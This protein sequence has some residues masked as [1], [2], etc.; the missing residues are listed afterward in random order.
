MLLTPPNFQIHCHFTTTYLLGK[1][2]SALSDHPGIPIL[3]ITLKK[4]QMIRIGESQNPEDLKSCYHPA[5][6]FTGR[7]QGKVIKR[8][9][10]HFKAF[11]IADAAMSHYLKG[12]SYRYRLKDTCYAIEHIETGSHWG[13]VS[14]SKG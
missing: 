7:C 12:T 2:W 10:L 6:C 9:G 13:K 11:P 4:T 3:E 5:N 1:N 14:S 8:Y